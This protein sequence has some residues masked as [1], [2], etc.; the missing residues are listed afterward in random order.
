MSMNRLTHEPLSRL[1]RCLSNSTNHP[2]LR[3]LKVVIGG[4]SVETFTSFLEMLQVSKTLQLVHFPGPF[5]NVENDPDSEMVVRRLINEQFQ[6]EKLV[7]KLLVSKKVAFL[8]VLR[9]LISAPVSSRHDL[10]SF[11]V[12]AVF[13]FAADGLARQI[14]WEVYLT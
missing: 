12:A 10:E 4:L 2:A 11:V 5:W 1:T 6:G 13:R 14:L 8:S 3:E 7:S 9:R